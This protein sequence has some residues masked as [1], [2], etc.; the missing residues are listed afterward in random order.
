MLGGEA[1]Q[2][3]A[4]ALEAAGVDVV[5][6]DLVEREPVAAAEQRA[7]DERDPEPA[8]TDDRELHPAIALT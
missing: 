1:V 4:H 5:Q 7:V 2:H 3:A 6:H 8:A